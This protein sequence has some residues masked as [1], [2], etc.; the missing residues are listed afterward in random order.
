MA[1]QFPRARGMR[2][3]LTF[4]VALVALFTALPAHALRIVDYNITNY[5]SVQGSTRDPYFR[6][7]F[8]TMGA[9]VVVV[10]EMEDGAGVNQFLANLNAVEPGQWINAPFSMATTRTTRCSTS[11]RKW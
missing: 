9:D 7:I 2:A 4:L 6:T 5:P 10:Q 11:R 3:A 1:P 8:A